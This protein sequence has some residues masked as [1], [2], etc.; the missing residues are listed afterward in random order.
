MRAWRYH[1]ASLAR[2]DVSQRHRDSKETASAPPAME[3]VGELLVPRPR[4][5]D[6]PSVQVEAFD[7]P[8][9]EEEE[10][11]VIESKAGADKGIDPG[12]QIRVGKEATE[13][14][15]VLRRPFQKVPM[16]EPAAAAFVGRLVPSE[17]CLLCVA[18]ID[19]PGHEFILSAINGGVHLLHFKG[20]KQPPHHDKTLQ[21]KKITLHRGCIRCCGRA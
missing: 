13:R 7:A 1:K 19:R 9:L 2:P 4:G 8:P 10:G 14:P 5:P 11:E 20:R 17:G 16:L 21:I 3:R 6:R 12:D 18:D 15:G